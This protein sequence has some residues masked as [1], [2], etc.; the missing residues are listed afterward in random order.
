MQ[1][2][3]REGFLVFVIALFF[4]ILYNLVNLQYVRME[5]PE[6]LRNNIT[7]RTADDGAYLQPARIFLQT[8]KWHNGSP[9]IQSYFQH[10]PGYGLSWLVMLHLGGESNALKLQ[11]SFQLL[12]HALTALMLWVMIRAYVSSGFALAWALMFAVWPGT[13][14][15]LFYTLT[16]GI[17][18]ALLMG[19]VFSIWKYHTKMHPQK[20]YFWLALAILIFGWLFITRPVLGIFALLMPVAVLFKPDHKPALRLIVA[21][22]VILLAFSPMLLWQYRNYTIAGRFT[23]LHPVYFPTEPG[24]FRPSHKSIWQL[25]KST[26]MKGADFHSLIHTLFDPAMMGDTTLS[27]RKKAIELTP[28]KIREAIGDSL[29]MTGFSLYQRSTLEQALI[30]QNHKRAMPLAISK[31]EQETISHFNELAHK[32]RSARPID[33]YILAPMRVLGY[34]VLHSNLNLYVFQHSWRGNIL[35]EGFR[36]LSFLLHVSLFVLL[37]PALW[38]LHKKPFLFG[39]VLASLFYVLWIAWFQRGVEER[40]TLPLLPVLFINAAVVMKELVSKFSLQS[41]LKVK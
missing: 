41:F 4:P 39:L 11:V 27:V 28:A 26:A 37:L 9:G 12:L 25:C 32:Y 34:M 38:L 2:K 18:P 30:T 5:K 17:S 14:G 23:G 20:Q 13:G 1:S 3:L 6:L 31:K 7:I 33:T 19:Y 29:L 8:N 16:E 15:F 36:I 21:G 40:Y 35:M 24:V 22:L 10:A